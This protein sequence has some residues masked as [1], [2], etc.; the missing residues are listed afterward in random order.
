MGFGKAL[1]MR[2]AYVGALF[3][4]TG[5]ANA[6]LTFDLRTGQSSNNSQSM[7]IDSNQCPT[8]G[9]T[10]MFVGGIITNTGTSTVTN[11]AAS[12]TGLDANVYLAGGQSSTQAIGSLGAGE[13]IGV[14]W[15]TGY[16]CTAGAIASPSI[17]I[18]SSLGSQS[19]GLTLTIRK[20]ISANAGG[21][22]ESSTLGAGAVVG[23]NVYFDAVY[24]FG[25]SAAG[26]EFFLQPAGGQVFNAT[27]FRLVGSEI[28]SSNVNAAAV[29]TQNRLY[30]TQASSQTGNGYFISVRYTFQYLCANT[31]TVARPYAVQTSGSTNIKY[32]GNFDGSGSISVIY[33]GAT[34]PFTITKSVSTALAF[35]PATSVLNYTVTISNPSSHAS[36]ISKIVD[37]LPAGVS[38]AALDNSGNVTV[39]NSS[40]IP[41]PGATG[42]ITFEGKLG[43][44]YAIA[45]GGSV[46]LKYT[47]NRPPAAGSFTNSAQAYFGSATTP[48]ATATFQQI[49]PAPISVSKTSSVTSDGISAANPKAIPNAVV[50]Y[51]IAITN[52]NPLPVD[53]GSVLVSDRTPTGIVMCVTDI[54]APGNGPVS[55]IEGSPASTLSYT[56]L[57]LSSA[58]DSIEFSN[59]GGISWNYTPVAD[60]NGCDNSLTNFRIR[61][62]GDFAGSSSF[63]LRAAYRIR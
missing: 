46:T 22:V 7:I 30:F 61:P 57:G 24:D 18:S 41:A 25:G 59:D 45:A 8:K 15:F 48:V 40:N 34:N 44:S 60:S 54:G 33:P 50:S 10:S 12:F 17:N 27:C 62:I 63:I 19:T 5:T 55:F 38:F 36:T 23:Q 39:T 43:Q 35:H 1:V 26:D 37:I 4:F 31:S 11:V 32:T 49:V 3:S 20:A 51:L 2:L 53:T 21:R 52:P 29:G 47:A 13:S 6:A 58:T 14:Y 9:P 28:R 42:T 16:G 56:F